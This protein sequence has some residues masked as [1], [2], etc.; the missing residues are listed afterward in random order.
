MKIA[1]IILTLILCCFSLNAQIK[2]MP[3]T[4]ILHAAYFNYELLN[5]ASKDSGKT[6]V[7]D[8]MRVPYNKMQ[9]IKSGNNFIASYTISISVYDSTKNNL[10]LEKIWSEKVT[11]QDFDQTTS[12]KNFNLSLRSFNLFPGKYFFQT[13]VEDQDSRKTVRSGKIMFEVRN[14]SNAYSISDIMI[15]YKRTNESGKSNILPNI[16]NNV[17]LQERTFPIFY[18][19]YSDSSENVNLKYSLTDNN[20]D[21]IFQT[22]VPYTLK[23]GANQILYSYV[24]STL[25]IG[26]YQLS[27]NVKSLKPVPGSDDSTLFSIS[28]SFNAIL[29]GLP[30]NA[31]SIGEA[32]DELVYIA[33]GSEMNYIENAKTQKEKMK[34]YHDF[35]KKKDP[36]PS[37]EENPIFS[38]YY[39][40]VAFANEHFSTYT[41][42]WKTDRGMI[43][44][45]LGP[46]NSVDRHPF[47]IDSKPYEV[48]NY[49]NL[50][51][52][53]VFVDETGFGDYR[54]VT[55]LTSDMYRYRY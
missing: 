40:R 7:D 43:Y 26:L 4:D 34:R 11:T 9:F 41:K 15:I 1:V 52:Q 17:T 8:Y 49:Y 18:E 45:T 39:G 36:N 27:V 12:E 22:T 32:V 24:D 13:S 2:E 6:R 30:S 31:K 38:E 48:W 46:P 20:K 53:L 50:D 3:K 42:G 5:F 16:T 28:K 14:L 35:W 51:E 37:T 33:T 47:D 55:P 25:D 44:I 23:K 54:L 29:P 21:N 19:I 10:I